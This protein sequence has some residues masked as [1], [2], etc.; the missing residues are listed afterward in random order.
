MIVS[1][2]KNNPRDKQNRRESTHIV[3]LYIDSTLQLVFIVQL[4]RSCGFE[5]L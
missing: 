4:L 3:I 2:M 1:D 5:L